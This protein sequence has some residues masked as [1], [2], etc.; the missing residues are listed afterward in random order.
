MLPAWDIGVIS[1]K[2]TSQNQ[3]NECR[4]PPLMMK[5][6]NSSMTDASSSYSC[7]SSVEIHQL[8]ITFKLQRFLLG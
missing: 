2:V 4:C 8:H 6:R 5:S 1:I 7:A 3:F